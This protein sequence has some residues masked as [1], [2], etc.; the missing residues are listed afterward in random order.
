MGT[1]PDDVITLGP[2]EGEQTIKTHGNIM[3]PFEY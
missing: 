1:V 2:K 3:R